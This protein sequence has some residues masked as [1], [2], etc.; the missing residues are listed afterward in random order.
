V[1][2]CSLLFLYREY[3]INFLKAHWSVFN[4]ALYVVGCFLVLFLLP[5]FVTDSLFLGRIFFA[6]PVASICL[7]ISWAF[8]KRI[9]RAK[10]PNKFFLRRNKLSSISIACIAWLPILTVIGDYQWLTF[11]IVNISFFTITAIEID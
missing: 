7:Y 9:S 5:Y 2:L 8:Y 3:D 10:N 11:T 4:I 1:R 6:V